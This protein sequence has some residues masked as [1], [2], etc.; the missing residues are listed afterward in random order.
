APARRTSKRASQIFP[1]SACTTTKQTTNG[2]E[3]TQVSGDGTRRER[4]CKKIIQSDDPVPGKSTHVA[5]TTR[6]S[7]REHAGLNA[8]QSI[9]QPFFVI[10]FVHGYGRTDPEVS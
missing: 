6:S 8:R 9:F 5:L 10:R 1:A 3:P 7:H 2:S 4:S